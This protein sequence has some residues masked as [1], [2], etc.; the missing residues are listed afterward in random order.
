MAGLTEFE[1][2]V[3]E[4]IRFNPD[5][6]K[7]GIARAVYGG[8]SSASRSQVTAAISRLE[9]RGLVKRYRWEREWFFLVVEEAV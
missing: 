5:S 1:T 6:T 9:K 2:R 7:V 8:V 3:L 4:A